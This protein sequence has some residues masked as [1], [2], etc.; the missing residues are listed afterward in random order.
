MRNKIRQIDLK[1]VVITDSLFGAYARRVYEKVIPHQWKILNDELPDM[2]A[3]HCIENFRAAANGSVGTRK[4]VVFQDT[5]LYKWIETVSYCILGG[6]GKE[7]ESLVDGA[8]DLIGSAQEEDGYLNTYYTVNAPDK[9]WGNLIEGHEL[10]T[11]GHLIEAAVAYYQATGKVKLLDIAVKNADLI[12]KIFGCSDNQIRGYPGHQEIELALVK[13]FRI[14]SNKKYL[15]EALY[16]INERG[17]KPNYFAKE[18]ETRDGKYEFF[19]EFYDYQLDYSQNDEPVR[20]QKEA[21]G[22]AVRAMYMYTAMADLASELDD[23]ELRKA[24]ETL[25]N[26]VVNTRMYITG[27]IGS[28]GFRE[29][30]TTDYDL[31]NATN[32]SETCASIGLMMFGQRMNELTK[33]G[34][35]YD[36]VERAL[37]N[38]VLASINIEGDRYFYVNPLEV[39]PEFCTEYTYMDHVK[40]VRQKWFSV[41]CCPPNVARTLA[42]LGQYIYARGDN[43]IYIHQFISSKIKTALSSGNI[44]LEMESNLLNDGRVV[45]DIK[46]NERCKLHIRQPHYSQSTLVIQ[47]DKE[48]QVKPV[49]GYLDIQLLAGINKID[50][51]F[52]TSPK[53][54]LADNRV[55]ENI[56]KAALVKG[57]VIYCLE[58]VDNG[59]LLG[60]IYVEPNVKVSKSKPV[61][62]LVG[63]VST[64]K[65]KGIRVKRVPDDTLYKESWYT[66]EE[67]EL[68]A[69]PYCMWNNREPGEMLVWHKLRI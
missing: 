12:C 6:N 35:Y 69:I 66:N 5:D 27:S 46:C 31:P 36:T 44:E 60:E 32:Y 67:V 7:Y 61:S 19:D 28:S 8:I 53:W 26:N 52:D 55:R 21:K 45:L 65:Y 58:E 24:C 23:E 64:I 25:W 62:G 18:L 41:A 38:T 39:V 29:R 48:I 11:A 3:T 59:N 63:E 2:V 30:F 16:F 33:D 49:K 14:T 37:Y 13:L 50:L 34:H 47:D 54:M 9:K 42:S 56:G 15:D 20:R 57:P 40:A 43:S 51:Q 17:C 68:T 4:G 10:Y 1:D 22:H